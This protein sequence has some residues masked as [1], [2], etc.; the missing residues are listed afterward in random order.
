MLATSEAVVTA[1]AALGGA[2]IGGAATFAG[3]PTS[4]S[5]TVMRSGLSTSRS[6]IRHAV[7]RTRPVVERSDGRLHRLAGSESSGHEGAHF[8]VVRH[9]YVGVV[10]R[11]SAHSMGPALAV[12][13]IVEPH[14]RV[15]MPEALASCL[16][17]HPKRG[18]NL[19][20]RMP[21]GTRRENL[22]SDH[23]REAPS[24]RVHQAEDV[25]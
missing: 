15:D 11:R 10:A 14:V 3:T 21:L 16:P 12:D 18:A 8:G 1:F 9:A 22:V 5:L 24:D 7:T 17:T 23:N 19:A 6:T 25:Q 2:L 20:P 4:D 13:V